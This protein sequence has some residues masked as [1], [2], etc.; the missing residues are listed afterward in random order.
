[1][2]GLF[3]A[4]VF[5]AA[6]F[7]P[8]DIKRGASSEWAEHKILG[9]IPTLERTGGECSTF[10]L[11]LT[12]NRR[13]TIPLEAGMVLLESY[14]KTG[15]HFPL[16]IGLQLVG[17]FSAP[18]FVITK[19]ETAY[20]IVDNRGR[21]LHSTIQC[22]F[23]QYRVASATGSASAGGFGS[24]GSALGGIASAVS[25][26]PAIGAISGAVSTVSSAITNAGGVVGPINNIPNMIGQVGGKALAVIPE[27]AGGS[28]SL[29]PGG[30][31]IS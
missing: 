12:F 15:Q 16:I 30:V 4:V 28:G 8:K 29:I 14:A 21:G 6:T 18:N 13:H 7:L 24:I 10:S 3:G 23:K 11:S 5:D 17:G 19:V 2:I 31:R 22:E 20:G 27:T 26:V 9:N 1:M 25:G